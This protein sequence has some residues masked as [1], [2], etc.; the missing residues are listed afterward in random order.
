MDAATKILAEDGLEALTMT[1]VAEAV[2]VVPGALY[3]YFASKDVLL[4]GMQRRTIEDI[5]AGFDLARPE[6][7]RTVAEAGLAEPEAALFALLGAARFYCDMSETLPERFRLL[8]VL[9]ADPR[10]LIS[11]DEA[12]VTA[13]SF[14]ALLGAVRDLFER[15]GT[16]GA[17]SAGDAMQR[18]LVY[19]SALQG[20]L[21]LSKLERYDPMF[22]GHRLALL[23]ARSLLVGWGADEAAITAAERAL[24]RLPPSTKGNER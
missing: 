16:S 9:L 5:Q 3:R 10:N 24:D 18:T 15:A 17:L 2:D 13:P 22:S 23:A 7:D 14:F 19:W 4:A 20:N 8:S 21:Q 11:F 1:R 12:Q 6:W